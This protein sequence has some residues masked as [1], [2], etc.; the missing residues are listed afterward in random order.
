MAPFIFRTNP[1]SPHSP[2]LG[3]AEAIPIYARETHCL[4]QVLK[5][6]AIITEPV[7]TIWLAPGWQA[8]NDEAGNLL[9]SAVEQA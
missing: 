9:L 1:L 2:I 4:K 5:G 6:P 8:I 3:L 7:S